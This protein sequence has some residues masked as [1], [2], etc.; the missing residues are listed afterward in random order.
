MVHGKRIIREMKKK[1]LKFY[2]R[3]QTNKIKNSYVVVIDKKCRDHNRE[4][5]EAPGLNNMKLKI[6]TTW[7]RMINIYFEEG[8]TEFYR[9]FMTFVI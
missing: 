2:M 7:R 8:Y 6:Q 1:E 4:F 5:H 9:N 3:V